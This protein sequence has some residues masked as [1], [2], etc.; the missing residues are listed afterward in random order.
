MAAQVVH[1]T[2]LR[3][4]ESHSYR[5]PYEWCSVKVGSVYITVGQHVPSTQKERKLTLLENMKR[6]INLDS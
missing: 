2:T 1:C 3:G 4:G 6:I 5:G